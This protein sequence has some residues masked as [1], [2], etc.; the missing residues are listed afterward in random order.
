MLSN[1]KAKLRSI[2]SELLKVKNISSK[3]G[4][5]LIKQT[6]ELIRKENLYLQIK[7]ELD[8]H[9][10]LNKQYKMYLELLRTLTA[11]WKKVKMKLNTTPKNLSKNLKNL[12]QYWKNMI[13]K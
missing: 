3:A 12:Y 5:L 1:N 11:E 4:K 13:M 8:Y 7:T 6:Q 2:S 9:N 10:N